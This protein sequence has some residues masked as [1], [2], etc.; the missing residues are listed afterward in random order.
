MVVYE[1]RHGAESSSDP[2]REHAKLDVFLAPFSSLPFD[3]ACAVK[4]AVIRR[5]LARKGEMI[6]PHDPRN[7]GT[8]ESADRDC[9]AG[10]RPL[11]GQPFALVSSGRTARWR[12]CGRP[13]LLRCDAAR[14]SESSA[15]VQEL[16]QAIPRRW[17]SARDIARKLVLVKHSPDG[18]QESRKF[19]SGSGV[20][21]S[22][23]REHHQLLANQVVERTLRAEVSLDGLRCP[24]LFNPNLLKP[25]AG[26]IV[27][28]GHPHK[29]VLRVKAG[30][31]RRWSICTSTG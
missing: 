4:C 23:V 1:L 25:H 27:S 9:G 24:A 21:A 19:F 29:I 14:S 8:F 6:R 5:A 31:V 15:Q 18:S 30:R 12:G 13:A 20:I 3:D 2:R 10:V 11:A 16:P 22:R 28:T 26:N 17:F 7:R